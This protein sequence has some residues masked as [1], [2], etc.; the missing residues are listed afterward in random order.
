[1]MFKKVYLIT[2]KEKNRIAINKLEEIIL[3]IDEEMI[4]RL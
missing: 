2:W 4:T 1:M 3:M